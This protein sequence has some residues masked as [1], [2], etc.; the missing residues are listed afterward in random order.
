MNK[1]LLVCLLMVAVHVQAQE[2]FFA[3][4]YNSPL[5]L[6][7]ALAGTSYGAVRTS[8]NYRSSLNQFDQIQTSAIAADMSLLENDRNPD[9]M[10]VGLHIMKDKAGTFENLKSMVTV[11]YHKS[12]GRAR[13]GYLAFGIQSGIDN[14]RLNNQGLSTQS[15]WT[16]T[17]YDATLP[18][19][20]SF[21]YES[22][23][24]VD[25]QAG[26]LWYSFPS[27]KSSLL[28]GLATFHIMPVNRSFL[29]QSYELNQKYVA[30]ASASF[31]MSRKVTALPM[32]MFSVQNG[33]AVLYPGVEFEYT[34]DKIKKLSCGAWIRN[35]DAC[36]LMGGMEYA[37]FSAT[38]SY[39]LMISSIREASTQGGIEFKVGYKFSKQLKSATRYRSN[40]SPRF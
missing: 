1:I 26:A 5:T 24:V 10:G 23:S 35:F 30:H 27:D 34:V 31:Q 4:F 39:D 9:Y 38:L 21:G 32:V 7:P 14:S 6:N 20:E 28:F 25:F 13:K 2:P 37:Q 12:V 16:P 11:S 40:P 22:V 15:Q 17:G 8:L 19:G 29:G 36:T 3:Q 33:I 18:T